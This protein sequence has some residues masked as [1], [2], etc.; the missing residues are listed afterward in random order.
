VAVGQLFET[1]GCSKVRYPFQKKKRDL[2][3]LCSHL[4]DRHRRTAIARE[5]SGVAEANE[6]ISGTGVYIYIYI[7]IYIKQGKK[8]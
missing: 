7:Y 4:S 3:E 1:F 8:N 6:N 2:H 5:S